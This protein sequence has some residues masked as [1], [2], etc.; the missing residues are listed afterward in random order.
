M[1]EHTHS[2]STHKDYT[3]SKLGMWLFLFTE[4]LLFGGLF[5]VYS[6]Y[7]S[8][9]SAAFHE[10]AAELDVVIGTA[11]TVILLTSSLCMAL[12]ISALQRGKRSSSLALQ[13]ATV[14]LGLVFLV[15]KYFEWSAKIHHGIY[16][17]SEELL[18]REHGQVLFY[19]LYYAM[20]GLH[21]IH[22][23]AGLV[24]LGIMLALTAADRI[25]AEDFGRLEN[26]GLYWHLVDLIWIYL[27]PLFYLIT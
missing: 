12:S 18:G 15:N 11:N 22:V 7:R 4:V 21:G 9:H 10:A 2:V 14:L 5:L 26:A 13:S 3:G 23:V 24:L 1:T 8:T 25:T 27:F 6:V 20:T 19:G 17:G 16:P